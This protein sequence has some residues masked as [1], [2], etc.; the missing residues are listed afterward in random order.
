MLIGLDIFP[1]LEFS[2]IRV[3]VDF[4]DTKVK[5][6]IVKAEE[7]NSIILF[8]LEE[9]EKNIEFKQRKDQFL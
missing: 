7:L 3:L 2:I 6:T 4:P 5:L 1:C 9:D 8:E